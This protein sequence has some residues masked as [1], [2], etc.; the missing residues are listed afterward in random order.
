MNNLINKSKSWLATAIAFSK[1]ESETEFLELR[2][3]YTDM[4]TKAELIDLYNK[5]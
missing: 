3:F 5:I 2:S 1:A 4:Y